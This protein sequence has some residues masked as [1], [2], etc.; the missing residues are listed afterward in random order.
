MKQIIIFYPSFE[1]GG[2]EKT[3][4]NLLIN[5]SHKKIKIKLLS[6]KNSRVKELEKFNN[7]KIIYP[8]NI[9]NIFSNR[10][11]T[12]F[13]CALSLINLLKKSNP[14]QTIVHSMQS[15][16]IPIMICK[17]FG[18]KIVIRNSEDPISSLKHDSNLISF[19]FI[20]IFRFIFYN[21]VDKIITN[22]RG[23][24]KSLR[25]FLFKRNFK[26]VRYIYNPFINKIKNINSNKKKIIMSA[27]RLTK[28]KNFKMLILAFIKSKLYLEGYKLYIYGKGKEKNNLNFLIKSQKM[29]KSVIL[30]GYKKNLSKEYSKAKIFVLSSIY[31]GLGN[32]LIEAL[33]HGT[34]CIATNCRSGPNEI[35]LFGKGGYIV[36]IFDINKLS[37]V[38]KLSIKNYSLSQKKLIYARNELSRFSS[39][40]QCEEYFNELKNTLK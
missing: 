12:A 13:S 22:S 28:Q 35:L 10:V 16:V 1:K 17:I 15:N 31:E 27:G 34:P 33:N 40:K 23:S 36:P 39:K 21:C 29:N 3:L 24:A 18:Y 2:L 38:L 26:K 19:A 30:K 9:I 11:N 8:K 20:C 14:D 37:K 32:V 4:T 7:F 25:F 5:F 6:S